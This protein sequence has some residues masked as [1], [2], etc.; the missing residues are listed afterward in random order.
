MFDFVTKHKRLMMIVLCILIIPPFAFFGIDFY[1]R[2]TGAEGSVA[3]VS[4]AEISQQEFGVALRQAQDRM[5]DAVRDNPQLAARLE[6]PEFKEAV[7]NDLIQRR[8]VLG[9]AAANGMLVSDGELRQ[10]IAGIA[11]F[12]D[13]NGNFSAARY[14]RLLRAQGMTPTMFESTIRQD[15]LLARIQFAYA[16]T[17]FLPDSVVERLVRIR[18][19]QRELSQ[20]VFEPGRYLGKAKVA[21]QDAR[22]YYDEHPAEFQ[23]PERAKLEYVVLTPEIAVQGAKISD[24]DLRQAYE[25]RLSQFQTQE[26]RSASHILIAAGSSASTEEKAK[27]KTQADDLARQ[28]QESPSRFAGLAKKF[29]QDPGSAEQGGSLGEL[30]RGLMVK[31][32]EDAVFGMK[33][34]GEIIGPVESEYGYHIIRLDGITA[35]VTTPFEEVR[36]QLL[37]ELRK[38]RTQRAF[39]EAAQSFG[40][41]VYEQYESLKPVA[42]ALKLTIQKTD[43]VGKAG[44]NMNP[45]F[46]NPKLLEQIFSSESVNS[47]RNTEAVEVQPNM[48]LSARIVEHLAASAMPFEEVKRDILEH[49]R[50]QQAV[51]LAGKEGRAMLDKLRKGET[52]NLRWSPS[53]MVTLVRRQGLHDEAVRAVFS[54][55]TSRL[56]AYA[57]VSAPDGRFVLYR[58]TRVED[59]PS[60]SAEQVRAASG[61]IAQLAAQEQFAAFVTGLREDAA[62]RIDKA[63]LMPAQQ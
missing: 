17:A 59:P 41:M 24:E 54:T 55:D 51:E 37:E 22:K 34:V 63:K 2:N 49:L 48:L 4:G 27:A 23:L 52:V 9:W 5:R 16:T 20:A 15:I 25:S 14:E 1:F 10:V 7:L 38:E 19:Q 35:P 26:K 11:A 53:T 45:V 44:G 57:G 46:N 21:E 39:T 56:P 60:V 28:L 18:E 29:S 61:Q 42:D 32:F 36:A 40:D 33:K 50:L 30:E 43:W 47:R 62:V 12:R 13:E 8:V 3:T 31:P 6:S 58:I